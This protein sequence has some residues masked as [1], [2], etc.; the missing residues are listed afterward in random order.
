MCFSPPVSEGRIIQRS[1]RV[2]VTALERYELFLQPP[3]EPSGN[4]I[5]EAASPSC[6]TTQPSNEHF[7]AGFEAFKKV[8]AQLRR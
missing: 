7:I 4:L 2:E 8:I 1:E 6:F 3:S 5:T